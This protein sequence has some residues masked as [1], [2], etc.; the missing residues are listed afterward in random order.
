[1]A[2]L[3]V[4]KERVIMCEYCCGEDTEN[5][6]DGK[7]EEWEYGLLSLGCFIVKNNL[8][9]SVFN[10]ETGEHDMSIA[11]MSEIKIKYCPMC[12][13]KLESDTATT[14]Q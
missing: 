8:C 3:F 4:W 2:V 10:D 9:I 6:A 14:E 12:G 13:R 11:D 5:I 1:M 7:Y